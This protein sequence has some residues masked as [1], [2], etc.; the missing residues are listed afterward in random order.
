MAKPKKHPMVLE[1]DNEVLSFHQWLN[2][3]M[4][5]DALTAMFGYEYTCMPFARKKSL[6]YKYGKWEGK[7]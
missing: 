6:I 1:F 5:D 4:W 3:I 2:I 7:M